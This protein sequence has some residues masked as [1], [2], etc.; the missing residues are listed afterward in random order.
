MVVRVLIV[1]DSATQRRLCR[2]TLAKDP[3]LSVIGEAADPFEARALI[4]ALRPDVLT[5][6]IEMPGMNGLE[7][8]RRI[9][10]LRPMPVVMLSNRTPAGCDAALEALSLGAVDCLAKTRDAFCPGPAGLADR[11]VVAAAIRPGLIARSRVI[12]PI[13]PAFRWNGK[14]V[15]VGASTG[16]VEALEQVFS[17]FPANCPP[18]MVTQHMPASYL[19]RFAIRLD[20]ALRPSVRLAQ[21]GMR[22][23]PGNIYL[24]PGGN[25]HLILGRGAGLTLK[26][27]PHDRDTGHCPS[28][29]VMFASARHLAPQ[30][31]AVM[32]TGMGRD[33]ATAMA[34]LH[35]AGARCLA[36]DEASSTVFGMPG[37]A[38]A[39]G[40]V[41]RVLPLAELAVEILTLTGADQEPR[42]TRFFDGG[43]R[44]EGPRRARP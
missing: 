15:L 19:A 44:K 38:I 33:G 40:A 21:A 43:T 14:I 34:A 9:M 41:E 2:S 36:Q 32:L 31:V 11:L 7:F 25:T 10:R 5:L 4:K 37:A 16:G 29:E 20:K 3:R 42:A 13:A 18:V 39:A 17:A 27:Q 26:L 12:H 28:V 30:V 24:A 8:L 6:D 35:D 22:V 1:D 23:E